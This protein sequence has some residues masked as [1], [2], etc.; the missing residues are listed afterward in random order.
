MTCSL[1][2]A[3]RAGLSDTS[4]LAALPDDHPAWEAAGHY[5]GA[6]CANIVL[7]AA[8]ERIVLSGGV[9]LRAG[10]FPKVRYLLTNYL[11]I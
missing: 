9:M 5:L 2:L 8:P 6:L 10:L 4:Q 3:K 11:R 1:A 7:L